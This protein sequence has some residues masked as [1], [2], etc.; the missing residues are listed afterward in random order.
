MGTFDQALAKSLETGESK[1][2]A[3]VIIFGSEDLE[4]AHVKAHFRLNPKTGRREFIKDYDDARHKDEVHIAFKKG[5]KVKVNNPK[6]KHHGKT[7]EV[8]G[9]S[10]KYDVVRGNIDGEKYSNDFHADHLE[11]HDGKA[12]AGAPPDLT[13]HFPDGTY[14][15]ISNVWSERASITPR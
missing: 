11:H 14:S 1:D 13:L 15:K 4:K 2:L 9:Y 6:S 5:D 12:D 3:R 7:M 10:D 8:T